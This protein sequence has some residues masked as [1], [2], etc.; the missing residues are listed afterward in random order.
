MPT[1]RA[2]RSKWP[3]P[4]AAA[5]KRS[6]GM[7]SPSGSYSIP[8]AVALIPQTRSPSCAGSWGFGSRWAGSGRVSTMLPRRRSFPRWNGKCCPAIVSVIL[9]MRR[10]WLST[11][12]TPS[13]ITNAGTVPPTGSHPSTTRSGNP[14]PSRKRH[15]KPSTISGEP[16]FAAQRA[17]GA[18]GGG[19]DGGEFF[20]G[21]GQ[22]ILAFAGPLVGQ[23]GVVAAHQPLAGKLRG[24]DLEQVLGIEQR[25]L[26]RALLDQRFDLRGA[27]CADP[28]QLPGAH[29]V[30][31]AGVGEHAPIPDQTHPGQPEPGFDLGDLGGQGVGV[32]GVA[33]EH[34]D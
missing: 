28:V 9:S 7:R 11:G 25:Q 12:A 18:A 5:A 31:D 32:G 10:L 24:A 2:R 4:R 13:T 22:Q 3:W 34:L 14:R 17:F 16:H 21:G 33:L 6:G 19:G 15:R 30:A 29:L 20:F 27:Q 1:W 23:G 26:Q 8:T